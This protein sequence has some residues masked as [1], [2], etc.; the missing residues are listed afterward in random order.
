VKQIDSTASP[1]PPVSVVPGFSSNKAVGLKVQYLLKG[2]HQD[3]TLASQYTGNL[4]GAAPIL[5]SLNVRHKWVAFHL[6]NHD[7]GGLA[8]DSNLIPASQD[9]NKAF[10]VF[11]TQ[12]KSRHA[13]NQVLWMDVTLSYRDEYFVKDISV[14]G[15]K[16]SLNKKNKTWEPDKTQKIPDW[17]ASIPQPTPPSIKINDL[18][19]DDRQR[20]YIASLT[21]M[22]K[23]LLVE[24]ADNLPPYITSKEMLIRYVEQRFAEDPR[25]SARYINQIKSTEIDFSRG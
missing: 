9:V 11:E 20:G 6:L 10:R 5:K 19:S 21:P 16:M 24:L 17:R 25:R 3:G 22:E 7:T 12:W 4:H 1:V 18:P 23:G 8:V 15:G 2:H 13:N 14:K